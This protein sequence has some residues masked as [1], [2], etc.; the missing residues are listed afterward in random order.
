MPLKFETDDS[1]KCYETLRA[2]LANIVQETEYDELYGHKLTPDAQFYNEGVVDN[3]IY[4]FCKANQFELEGSKSQLVK[5]LKWRK[6]FRPLHAAFSETHDSMLNDVCAITVDEKND[7]NQKVIS[8]N[9]YGLLVKHKEVFEDTDKF[10][11]FRIGLMERGLQLLDFESEDNHL[12][13]QVHDYDNVSM[14][15]LDPGIKK[16]S[17]AIIEV[18][19]DFYPE[20]LFSKFFV[21]VPYIMSWLYEIVKRFVSEDT[22]K[23]FIVL[24]DGKQMKEYLKFPP[25]E[26]GGQATLE[27]SKLK[28]VTPNAYVAH[29]LTLEDEKTTVSTTA[30]PLRNEAILT[31]D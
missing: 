17:K 13:T 19:Q 22:R 10:L 7:A 28:K 26:Y 30:D 1:K 4:K 18:F 15:K 21:N 20:T 27:S 3:L 8:W 2:D 14:W 12:M 16:C 23:K 11:R 25:K 24:S 9:L 6:E 29:L 5:T 31:V